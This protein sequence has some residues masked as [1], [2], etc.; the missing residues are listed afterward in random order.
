MRCP[1]WLQEAV[2]GGEVTSG[3]HGFPWDPMPRNPRD[4]M[5]GHTRYKPHRFLLTLLKRMAKAPV[6]QGREDWEKYQNQRLPQSSAES[7]LLSFCL[8][9]SL[10]TPSPHPPASVGRARVESS[11]PKSDQDL[12]LPPWMFRAACPGPASAGPHMGGESQ[13]HRLLKICI[14]RKPSL[15][16]CPSPVCSSGLLHCRCLSL[17]HRGAILSSGASSHL[18]L[19]LFWFQH[20]LKAPTPIDPAPSSITSDLTSSFSLSLIHFCGCTGLLADP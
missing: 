3:G 9:P 4:H 13:Q 5:S 14:H 12:F 11:C 7:M 15:M 16:P 10:R 6:S 2:Q 20:S 18:S 19:I 1:P 17:P 8:I